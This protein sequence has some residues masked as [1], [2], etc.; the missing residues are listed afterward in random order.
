MCF[1]K[2]ETDISF[3][4]LSERLDVASRCY[5][6]QKTVATFRVLR[7][8]ESGPVKSSQRTTQL[9]TSQP[10]QAQC[11]QCLPTGRPP[12][13]PESLRK[14]GCKRRTACGT[15][16][17]SKH[18]TKRI[19]AKEESRVHGKLPIAQRT[20]VPLGST[21]LLSRCRRPSMF[22]SRSFAFHSGP[23][24][25]GT[26]ARE[27]VRLV[28]LLN[29]EGRNVGTLHGVVRDNPGEPHTRTSPR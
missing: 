27:S 25:P 3:S 14:R 5:R 28:V 13:T 12:K 18:E 16:A 7:R 19:V 4:Q 24:P 21:S 29:A 2:S 20:I 10:T 22:M 23:Q 6:V 9:K 1:W 15:T 11:H 8:K 26:R 17:F